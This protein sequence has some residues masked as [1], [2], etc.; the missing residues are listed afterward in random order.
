MR[1]AI[2]QITFPLDRRR[3]EALKRLARRQFCSVSAVVRQAVDLR[4]REEGIDTE[5]EEVRREACQ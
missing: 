5:D 3:H 4:L 2:N 1:H